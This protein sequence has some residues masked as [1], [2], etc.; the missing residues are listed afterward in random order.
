MGS[1][2]DSSSNPTRVTSSHRPPV[3]ARLPPQ[4]ASACSWLPTATRPHHSFATSLLEDGDDIRTIQELLVHKD[5]TT[6]MVNTH[7]LTR[8]G[9]GVRI[10]VDSLGAPP[11]TGMI[12][13]NQITSPMKLEI[14]A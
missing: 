6:T 2:K 8:G 13:E 7:V 5:V 14:A 4:R 1:T 12:G 11:A 3:L 10:P 9:R